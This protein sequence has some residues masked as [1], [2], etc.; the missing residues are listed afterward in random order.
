MPSTTTKENS[1]RLGSFKN[2]SKDLG[3]SR[4]ASGLV[5]LLEAI[6]E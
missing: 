5:V 2:K 1:G 6:A 3:V 4:P